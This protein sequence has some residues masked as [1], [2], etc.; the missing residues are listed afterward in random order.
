M[1]LELP[2][3]ILYLITRGATAD[4]TTAGDPTFQEIL[5]QVSA[6]TAAGIDLI[7][8]REKKLNARVLFELTERAVELTAGTS[9]RVLVNDRAD[10]AAGAGAA[11]AH[12]TTRSLDAT[13]IRNTFGA[14]FLIG[15]STHSLAE[16]RAARESGADFAV[17][18]PI[19]ETASKSEYG[20]PIGVENLKDA[21]RQLAPFPL[22]ALGGV[23]IET[24]GECLRAGASGIAGIRLFSNPLD[25]RRTVD[26]VR[27]MMIE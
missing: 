12:L 6:A 20:P 2:R 21:A 18:G 17:Y 10:I 1:K 8:I 19:F 3:L 16:A 14:D 7:Q 15:A 22:L 4:T 26:S 24:A 25:L 27:S 23:S 11:G 5:R 13:T 9:T